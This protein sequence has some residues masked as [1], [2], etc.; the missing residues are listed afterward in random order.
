MREIS[1]R[2]A[3]NETLREEMERDERVILLGEDISLYGGPRRVTWGLVESFGGDRV[4]DTPISE[5]TII[6]TGLGAAITGMRPVVEISYIDFALLAMDQIGNQVAKLSYMTG[7]QTKVPLVIRTQGGSGGGTAAQHSQSLEMLFVHIPG[8]KVVIP[9]TPYDAKGLLKT[10]IRDDGPV[11]FIEH[12]LLYVIKGMVSVKEYLIPF[13]ELAIARRGSDITI[14]TYSAMLLKVMEAAEMLHQ[15]G[16]EV[17]V[18][19]LRTL[20]PLDIDGVLASVK[21]TGRLLIVHEASLVGGMGAE[22]AA[23]VQEQAFD[24]LDAPITRLGAVSVPIPYSESLE[25]LVF[26]NKEKVVAAAHA[27][28]GLPSPSF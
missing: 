6:G 15:E 4:R 18:L 20:I 24:Y 25:R 16:I 19:D 5:N 23:Q 28:I 13:G 2:D 14:V 21:K 12:K 8:L 11:I 9:A 17:E 1:Y 22:I 3:I 26:P 10:A 7:G 27:L